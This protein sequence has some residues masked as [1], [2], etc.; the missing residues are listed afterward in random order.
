MSHCIAM[1]IIEVLSFR[2]LVWLSVLGLA[3]VLAGSG[4]GTLVLAACVVAAVALRMVFLAA[5]VVVFATVPA[6]VVSLVVP[7]VADI[8]QSRL[9]EF[10]VQGTNGHDRFVAPFWV[11]C[12]ATC[13]YPQVA[14]S[15]WAPARRRT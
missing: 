15:A 5:L 4:I 10:D 11:L 9:A 8:A 14:C 13:A 12:D 3:L 1:G 7:E 6:G 2:Q